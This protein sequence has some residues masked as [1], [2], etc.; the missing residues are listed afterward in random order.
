MSYVEPNSTIKIFTLDD[1]NSPIPF[2]VNMEN[3]V[4]FRDLEQQENYMN[5]FRPITLEKNSYA[6]VNRGSIK[7]GLTQDVLQ[8]PFV[9]KIIA[10]VYNANYMAFKNT[11]FENKW[12]YCF[13]DS[14]EYV[15]NN[16]VV[17]N[18]HIDPIQTYMFDYTF[19]QCLIEREHT[20]SDRIGEHTLSEG[21]ETGPY[22]SYEAECYMEDPESLTGLDFMNNRFEYLRTVVLATSVDITQAN[23]PKVYGVLIP[24]LFGH[25]G[26]GEYYSGIRYYSFPITDDLAYINELN[27]GLDELA[28]SAD[29]DAIVGIFIMPREFVPT[30][31]DE[32]EHGCQP[33]RMRVMRKGT[34]DTYTPR[35]NKLFCYPYN[36]LYITNN[37]GN[38]AEYKIE[39]FLDPDTHEY[40]TFSIWGNCSMQPGMYCAPINYNGVIDR[41]NF[42]DEITVT[43]F[44]MCSYTI[45]SFKAWLAQNAGVIAAT[46]GSLVAGWATQIGKAYATSATGLMNAGVISGTPGPTLAGVNPAGYIGKH[47]AYTPTEFANL[48]AYMSGS[49][50][51]FTGMIGATLGALGTLFDHSRKPP[52]VHGNSN[53]NLTYQ[54]GQMTF[55]WYHKQIRTEYAAIIDKFFDMYGY[56]TNRV[57]TPNLMARPYYSYVK[58]IGCS[59]DGMIPGD[60]KAAIERIFDKGIR[61]WMPYASFGNYDPDVNDNRAPTGGD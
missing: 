59:I 32:F 1:S 44:P 39:N 52:Q 28:G 54:A 53:G 18:Y 34:I 56:K 20:V 15:N 45:D 38:T 47:A 30:S 51:N 21:L 9:N 40:D 19:N 55:C 5:A 22:R 6:R 60:M 10:S 24:S 29:A 50:Q 36:E 27:R 31:A 42:D 46:A 23:F 2:D 16:T 12:F 11:S 61:F 8:T 57:G 37:N 26:G 3:T 13:I 41:P 7:V 35:N 25:G 14:T 49:Q 17:I 43:G 48:N 58:T 4:I 33:K